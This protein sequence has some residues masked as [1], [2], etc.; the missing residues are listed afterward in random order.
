LAAMVMT[1]TILQASIL[2]EFRFDF[3]FVILIFV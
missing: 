1:A 2:C 3:H